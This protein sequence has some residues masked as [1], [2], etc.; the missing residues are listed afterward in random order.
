MSL[1]YETATAG[2]SALD[3]IEKI[4]TGF[5]ATQYGHFIDDEQGLVQIVFKYQA[6]KVKLEASVKGY[7]E[8]YLKEHPYNN[9]YRVTFKQHQQRALEQARTSVYSILRDWIKSQIMLVESG[10]T[11]FEQV[12]FASI[13]EGGSGKTYF[14]LGKVNLG[15]GA[16]TG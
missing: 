5:G 14:E 9:R 1:P 7:A 15:A 13:L 2:R 4:L 11:T 10:L 16:I 3:Q 12:F 6:H 8:L